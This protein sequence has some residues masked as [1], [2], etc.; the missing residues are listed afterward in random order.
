MD[1]ELDLNGDLGRRFFPN[2][3]NMCGGE[4]VFKP[5]NGWYVYECSSCGAYTNAHRESKGCGRK[6]EPMGVLAD[7]ELRSAHDYLRSLFNHLWMPRQGQLFAINVLFPTLVYSFSDEDGETAVGEVV[8]YD[9]EHKLYTINT[10][11]GKTYTVPLALK[12][13]VS[14]RTKSYFWLAKQMGLAYSACQIPMLDMELTFKAIDVI[15]SAL[16]GFNFEKNE[17]NN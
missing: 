10:E 12:G 14:M 7:E 9:Q 13:K 8:E 4:V 6:Y 3:C 11:S 5:H 16:H 2:G 15:K 1:M 17:P